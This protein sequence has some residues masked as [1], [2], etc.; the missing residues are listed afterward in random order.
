MEWLFH[1]SQSEG[2]GVIIGKS[3]VKRPLQPTTS[4]SPA[5]SSSKGEWKDVDGKGLMAGRTKAV[6]K[7]KVEKR[8]L[9]ND[10]KRTFDDMNAG[11]KQGGNDGRITSGATKNDK[12]RKNE[13]DGRNSSTDGQNP[14]GG[15]SKAT[16]PS[17]VPLSLIDHS[18]LDTPPSPPLPTS[19][20]IAS[21]STLPVRNGFSQYPKASPH[22][23]NE[24]N[25]REQVR[26]RLNG[27]LGSPER[28]RQ[29]PRSGPQSSKPNIK[30][31]STTSV[32]GSTSMARK[33]R[34]PA[35]FPFEPPNEGLLRHS[36]Q[37]SSSQDSDH[38]SRVQEMKK[39]RV[40]LDDMSSRRDEENRDTRGIK[41]AAGDI[42]RLN[43]DIW[44]GMTD[45]PDPLEL[46]ASPFNHFAS[47]TPSPR[48]RSKLQDQN[49]KD[50]SHGQ[51]KATKSKHVDRKPQSLRHSPSKDS[52]GVN[53]ETPVPSSSNP[54]P[55]PPDARKVSNTSIQGA[56]KKR[57][58]T[59]STDEKD[60]DVD[61][62]P[63]PRHTKSNV[64]VKKSILDEDN[65]HRLGQKKNRKS[66]KREDED[67]EADD[68]A[69][70]FKRLATMGEDEKRRILGPPTSQIRVD[71][72]SR[73]GYCAHDYDYK[74]DDMMYLSQC[75]GSFVAYP[76]SQ[77]PRRATGRRRLSRP[78]RQGILRDVY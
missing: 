65:N 32:S 44:A 58:V 6:G 61:K 37:L 30:S 50:R 73:W 55:K 67:E 34:K 48:H 63:K 26:A 14:R 4:S 3:R 25:A 47:P 18:F 66:S 24:L 40:G 36:S 8:D 15:V 42:G 45:S 43:K 35:A 60:E 17:G 33:P 2:L 72:A 56:V 57:R 49:R 11:T 70:F 71:D 16:V 28:A 31:K 20:T 78:C 69:A 29:P 64:G 68:G 59:L 10:S 9:T 75:I 53:D 38:I 27:E 46:S 22:R 62:T 12:T 19:S 13:K 39:K 52:F 23:K 77:L 54:K 7:R 21:S 41:T 1:H 74:A 5:D 76:N 51:S